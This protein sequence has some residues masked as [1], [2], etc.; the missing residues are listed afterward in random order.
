MAKKYIVSLKEG[1]QDY[2]SSSLKGEVKNLQ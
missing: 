2:Y 1:E